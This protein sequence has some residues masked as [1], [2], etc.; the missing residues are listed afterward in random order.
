MM[1]RIALLAVGGGFLLGAT[2]LSLA[3]CS[4]ISPP[5]TPPAGSASTA[6]PTLPSS[7]K[8]SLPALSSAIPFDVTVP[9]QPPP[10]LDSL[11]HDFDVL[12]WQT[13]VAMSWPALPNG[14]PDPSQKPGQK[15]DNGTVWQNWRESSTIFLPN[16]ATPAPWGS[17]PPP[18]STLPPACQQ[19]LT[20]GVLFL[21]QIG[22]TPTLLTDSTQPFKT[23]PLIDQNGRYARFEILV[24]QSMFDTIFAQKLYNKQ[25][26]QGITSVV[27]DCG[28]PTTQ[29][30]G[31]IMVKAAWKILSA[32]EIASGRFHTAAA[33][34]YTPATTNPPTPEKCERATVGLVGLHI[35]HKTAGAPQWVWSTFEQVD[36]CPT[37]GDG[38]QSPHYN[39]YAKKGATLPPN[40]PPPLPW[41]PTNVEPADRRP[42]IVRQI[43]IDA[44]TKQLNASWQAALRAVNPASVWQYYELV[45]TQWPT[46][47]APACDVATSAPANMSGAPAPQFL[48]NSTLES[49]IQGKVPNVSSSCIEC[50][51]NA[52]TTA[53]KFSDFTYLLERAQ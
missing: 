5:T 42:Q 38:A 16:G 13:F 40:T 29:Q 12:S 6:A 28:N 22:K 49:Y 7:S 17:P 18:P 41:H 30:V 27:F 3:A 52:T 33:V 23:G 4:N 34:I 8:A 48:G 25:A 15:K 53:A 51:L 9:N 21:T 19:W 36:N 2:F 1:N 26:Q 50:H 39:F 35:V 46:Q 44:A 10:T 43:P 32:D 11:Q 37:D 45:S 14:Q 31:A 24:N 20:P 47:P